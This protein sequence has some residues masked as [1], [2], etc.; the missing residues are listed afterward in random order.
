M[1]WSVGLAWIKAPFFVLPK[2]LFLAP[3]A[4]RG[5]S[6]PQPCS[7]LV[8][9]SLFLISFSAQEAQNLSRP[10]YQTSA[11]GAS[12]F[13]SLVDVLETFC[14]SKKFIRRPVGRYG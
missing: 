1:T 12:S 14:V 8:S 10:L 7:R 6:T 5:A 3:N 11:F 13:F 2:A 4:Q 9:T